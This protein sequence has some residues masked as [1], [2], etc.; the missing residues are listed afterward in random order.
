MTLRGGALNS[1]ERIGTTLSGMSVISSRRASRGALADQAL[2][3]PAAVRDGRR[4]A[5]SA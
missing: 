3:Q 1:A 5:S 4:G 2:A